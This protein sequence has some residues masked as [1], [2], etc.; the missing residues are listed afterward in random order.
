M[1]TLQDHYLTREEV[2]AL[3]RVDPQTVSR[4]IREHK[5]PHPLRLGRQM[6]WPRETLERFLADRMEA[7]HA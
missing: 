2:A 6:L 1:N 3:L 7:A 5:I 4:W